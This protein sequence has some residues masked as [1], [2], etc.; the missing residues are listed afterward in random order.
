MKSQDR[1]YKNKSTA[2]KKR[3]INKFAGR[4][5]FKRKLCETFSAF[6]KKSTQINKSVNSTCKPNN[7]YHNFPTNLRS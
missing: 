3:K 6:L 5:N 4:R 7:D 2:M 1:Q